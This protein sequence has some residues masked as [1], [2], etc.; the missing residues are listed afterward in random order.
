M[1]G[2][3]ADYVINLNKAFLFGP[4]ERVVKVLGVI[5]DFV[6]KHTRSKSYALSNEVNGYIHKHSKNIPHKIAVTLLKEEKRIVVFLQKG[7][8]MDVYLKQKD[9]AKK[10]KEEKKAEKPKV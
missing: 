7:K 3:R 4:K 9:A 5:R 8:E 1:K 2:E 6:Y 10:K